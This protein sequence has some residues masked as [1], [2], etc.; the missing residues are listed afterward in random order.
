MIQNITTSPSSSADKA[1]AYAEKN[2]LMMHL[3]IY[4]LLL[5]IDYSISH[6]GAGALH[7]GSI[8]TYAT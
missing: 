2:D 8:C 4:S 3:I 6:H 1:A 5:M 7:R